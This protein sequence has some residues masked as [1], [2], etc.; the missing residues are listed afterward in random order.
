MIRLYK[1]NSTE[2]KDFEGFLFE[3]DRVSYNEVG[4]IIIDG[5]PAVLYDQNKIIDMKVTVQCE[6]NCGSGSTPSAIPIITLAE[7]IALTGVPEGKEYIVTDYLPGQ[8]ALFVRVNNEWQF[9]GMSLFSQQQQN[10]TVFGLSPENSY[11]IADQ[12]INVMGQYFPTEG[13]IAIML[14]EMQFEAF[15]VSNITPD[16]IDVVCDFSGFELGNYMLRLFF[17]GAEASGNGQF[18]LTAQNPIPSL[19]DIQPRPV[20][21]SSSSAL[22]F[23]GQNFPTDGNVTLMINGSPFG[24]LTVGERDANVI[25]G[26]IDLTSLA[27]NDY[28]AALYFD[29]I[30]YVTNAAA[31]SVSPE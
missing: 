21:A 26:T 19:T 7:L 1:V 3:T 20:V 2:Y 17:N 10:P 23:T 12:P 11:N 27:P 8:N 14:N 29:T 18:S 15:A 31:L 25:T 4:Q 5:D 30:S 13:Q 16:M 22:E 28:D 24:Q 6:C 9:V